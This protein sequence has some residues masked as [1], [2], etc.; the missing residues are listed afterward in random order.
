MVVTITGPQSGNIGPGSSLQVTSDFVGPLDATARWRALLGPTPLVLPYITWQIPTTSVTNQVKILM[1]QD[2]RVNFDEVQQPAVDSGVQLLANL[3][4]PAN[5]VVDQGSKLFQWVPQETIGVQVDAWGRTGQ[6]GG[7]TTN[8]ALQLTQTHE[9]VF[10]IVSS[11]QLLLTDLTPNGPTG[12]P[13]NQVITT[14]FFGII[15]R[16]AGVPAE[17][18]PTTPDGDYWF[19]SLAVVRV[20]RGSDLWARAPI[21]TSSKI[22][23]FEGEGVVSSIAKALTNLT[24]LNLSVQ[25]TFLPGVTGTVYLMNW[26]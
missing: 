11:D 4:S 5:T 16:I 2:N 13:V 26:P 1:P 7:L 17:L 20:Y 14:P 8:Q 3:E 25:V 18:L 10:P 24:L 22:V 6:G 19:H 12:G 23:N 21:H 15:V 9:S